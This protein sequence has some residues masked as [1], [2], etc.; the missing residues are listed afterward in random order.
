MND[1]VEE[2]EE[3]GDDGTPNTYTGDM[4]QQSSPPP[5]VVEDDDVDD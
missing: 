3:L 2:V 5:D 1:D 4:W